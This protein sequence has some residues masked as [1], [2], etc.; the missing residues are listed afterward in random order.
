MGGRIF[1]ALQFCFRALRKAGD[2]FEPTQ[3]EVL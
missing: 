3:M 2:Q 1:A